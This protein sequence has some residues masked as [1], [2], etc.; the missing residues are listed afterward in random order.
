MSVLFD[1]PGVDAPSCEL[2][3]LQAE[4]SVQNTNYLSVLLRKSEDSQ[5]S[6]YFRVY[7]LGKAGMAS[8][9]SFNLDEMVTGPHLYGNFNCDLEFVGFSQSASESGEICSLDFLNITFLTS[10]GHFFMLTPILL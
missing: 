6:H 7:N 10:N 4:F 9:L 1:Q 3:V 2:T 8:E 5:Q